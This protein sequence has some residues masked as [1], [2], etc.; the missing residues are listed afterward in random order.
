ML[1]FWWP[2][3]SF[4]FQPLWDLFCI[5][6]IVGIWPRFIEPFLIATTHQKVPI[7][8]LPDQLN[9]LK[10]LQFSDLHL[11]EC[12]SQS[13]LK[14]IIK[15]T[16]K[17]KPDIIVFTGD[18]LC[19]AQLKDPN[20]L[21]NFLQEF[22]APHGCYAIL[23][24]HDYEHYI[25][26]NK[27]GDYDLITDSKT[28][29]QQALYRLFN[30][31]TLTKTTTPGA[32]NLSP[33]KSLVNL[34]KTTP[35]Q[36]LHNETVSINIKGALLNLTGL[37]EYMTTD[38]LPQKAYIGIKENNCNITLLHNPDGLP[39]L[40]SYPADIVLCGHT[41]G[42]QVNLPWLWKKFTLLENMIFKKGVFKIENKWIYVNR[43]VGSILPFRW[44]STPEILLLTLE[45]N[46]L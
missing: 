46:D 18:F 27:N 5:G 3:I 24:N 21:R 44:F 20:R 16:H 41:H 11:N 8:N 35:F 30:S 32:Q 33:N 26:I 12:Q 22:N 29:L 14:K 13:F 36:L 42:G 2:Q 28:P 19:G 38:T 17:L 43:G 23:G 6:S 10:I 7:S 40:K 34:L 9:G 31:P 1:K 39:L 15:K 37:G 25:S 45:R 4:F